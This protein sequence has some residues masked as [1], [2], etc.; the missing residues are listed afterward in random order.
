MLPHYAPWPTPASEGVNVFAQPL[1]LEHNIY[2]FPPFVLLGPLLR[3]FLDRGFQRALTQVVPDLRPRRFW[4][5]LLQSVAVDRLLLGR[6]GDDAV[7]LVDSQSLSRISQYILVRD[8]TF[9]VMNFFTGDR[10]SDLGRLLAS[11]VFKLK[12]RGVT[13]CVLPILKLCVKTPLVLLPWFPFAKQTCARL[14][15]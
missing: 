1:P 6:K 15:G 14:I 7:L 3:Y 4:W 8:A 11:Q 12:D 13:C 2:A 5:A 9:F 10:A